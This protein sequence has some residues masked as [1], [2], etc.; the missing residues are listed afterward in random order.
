MSPPTACRQSVDTTLTADNW[1]DKYQLSL[2]EPRDE[3]VLQTEL[4]DHC[5][6]YG[7]RASELGGIVNL[8]DR[9]RSSLLRSER[10]PFS[11]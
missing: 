6:N 2:T 7:G 3:I 1:T 5:D 9:R 8:A 4:D 11:S 10:P